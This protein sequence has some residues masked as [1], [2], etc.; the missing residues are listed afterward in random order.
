[1]SKRS[2]YFSVSALLI[3]LSL[4]AFVSVAQA[5]Q[6]VWNKAG[7][8][9][10]VH[11]Y[12]PGDVLYDEKGEFYIRTTGNNH[13]PVAPAQLD[14]YPVAQGRCWEGKEQMTAVLAIKDGHLFNTLMTAGTTIVAGAATGLA[15]TA[16]CAA[17][18]GTLCFA[19]VVGGVATTGALTTAM[20]L[21]AKTPELKG[22]IP[23]AFAI[24]VPGA[25]GTEYQNRWL[26]VW[27]TVISPQLGPGGPL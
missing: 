15:G 2:P 21:S 13:K 20:Q 26:D 10:E 4:A 14:V 18:V 12:K 5:K 8:I 11:W 1:M 22:T 25:R 7:F 6:C 24:T 23:N 19:A 17:S 27:G 3:T 9:L 16:V